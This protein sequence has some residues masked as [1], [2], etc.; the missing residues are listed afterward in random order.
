MKTC[1]AFICFGKAEVR[2]PRYPT[3]REEVFNKTLAFYCVL[4]EKGCTF[5]VK[6]DGIE[7]DDL[8]EGEETERETSSPIEDS[9]SEL[10]FDFE[11]ITSYDSR[12]KHSTFHCPGQMVMRSNRHGRPYIQ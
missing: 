9:E 2:A 3:P 10:E 4:L 11:D 7:F 6:K 12:R 8:I 5:D 1:E